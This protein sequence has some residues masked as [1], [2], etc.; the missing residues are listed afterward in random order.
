MG[1][2]ATVLK[3]YKVEYGTRCGFNYGADYLAELI[4]HFCE[5]AW[6]GGEY[7]DTNCFWE[8]DKEEFTAMIRDIARMSDEEFDQIG[9]DYKEADD[10]YTREYVLEVFRGWLEETP[11]DNDYVRFGWV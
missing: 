8:V 2:R 11:P 3:T 9:E 5:D 10:G 6:L 1:L 4:E 7:H